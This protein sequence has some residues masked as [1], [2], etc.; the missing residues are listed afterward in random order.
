MHTCSRAAIGVAGGL[1]LMLLAGDLVAAASP[2]LVAI[3]QAEATTAVDTSDRPNQQP[4][5]TDRSVLYHVLAAPAYVLHGMTRPLGWGVR[6]VEQNHPGLFDASLPARGVLPVLELGGP[7]GFLGGLLLYDNQLFGS[8]HSARLKGLYG[9]PNTFRARAAYASPSLFGIGSGLQV[10]VNVLSNPR[11]GFFLG[12]NDSDREEDDASANR[13]QVDV[14][15]ALQGS[16]MGGVRGA[17]DVL[18]EHVVTNTAS[19]NRGRRLERANP[20]GLGTVDLLTSRVTVEKGWTK[21][22]RRPYLGTE[23]ILQ[24]DYTHDLNGRRFRYGRYVAE[25]R[26]YLPV[27]IFPTTRRLALRARLEQVAPVLRGTA[28]PFYQQPGLGGQS[29]LRGYQF[30]RLQDDGALVVSAEYRYPIWMNLD[31]VVFTDAGQVFDTLGDVR[32]P[33]LTWGYGGGIHLRNEDGLSFRA[34]VAAGTEGARAIL[35]VQPSFRRVAR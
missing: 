24:L 25:L 20:P 27:G 19:G 33:R 1:L 2:R 22:G 23:A 3:G 32:G 10:H 13:D 12:G 34:E 29:R 11:S 31:A 9:G 28:V 18:Y 6:Y 4:Y 16:P 15:V 30:N 35:T 7:T 26:Q 5:T 8:A 21:G 17:F 14:S